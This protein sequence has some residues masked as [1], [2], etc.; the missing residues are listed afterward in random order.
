MNKFDFLKD[1]IGKLPELERND[2]HLGY[3]LREGKTRSE[4]HQLESE[5]GFLIPSELKEFYEFSYG[6]LLGEYEILTA[7]EIADLLPELHKT[8]ET[9][10]RDTILPFAYVRGVGDVVVFDLSQLDEKG[11][12]L[13]IDGFHEL[14]PSQW[15]R[16]CFGL[17][18]W[19]KK[20]ANNHFQPFWLSS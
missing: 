20:M 10:R 14:P 18:E 2:R 19:L 4:I 8:Y 15:S 5:I 3:A 1:Y 12:I 11:H 6:A 13:I 7:K 17:E 16:I 9:S